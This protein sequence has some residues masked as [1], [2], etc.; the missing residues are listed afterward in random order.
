MTPFHLL[1]GQYVNTENLNSETVSDSDGAKY[2]QQS[3]A[4]LKHV[5]EYFNDR[6]FN[7]YINSLHER[8]L[9]QKER[10]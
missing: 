3:Y 1:Y 4:V 9:Q 8:Q 7:E 6:F 2:L 10:E 5:L